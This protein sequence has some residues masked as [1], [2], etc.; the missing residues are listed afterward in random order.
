MSLTTRLRANLAGDNLE[1]MAGT[2][3]LDNKGVAA[4]K[5]LDPYQQQEAE[6]MAT[7]GGVNYEEFSYEGQTVMLAPA[8]GFYSAPG[9]GKNEVRIS[10]CLKVSDLQAAMKCLEEALKVYPGRK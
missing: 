7:S 5:N 4:I 9:K 10:Y 8:T 6:T 1:L 2:V 3:T